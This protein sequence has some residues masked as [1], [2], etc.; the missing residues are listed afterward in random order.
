VSEAG[1]AA[2]T[3]GGEEE[4]SEQLAPV[5]Y[6]PV[7]IAAVEVLLPESHARLVLCEIGGQRRAFTVP[8]G[9]PEA[10]AI[11]YAREGLQTPR[12]LTHELFASSLA[13]YGIVLEAVRI[14]AGE[15]RAFRAE[16]VFSGP[17]GPRTLDCR[18]S[19]G[20]ALALRHPLPVPLTVTEAV[21]D[22]LGVATG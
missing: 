20:I 8:I 1:A 12:P 22:Q 16:V 17:S 13:A 7:E 21:L 2:D 4:G 14:T 19:D 3:A 11:V 9:I 18:P 6:C 10:N 15:D 5:R